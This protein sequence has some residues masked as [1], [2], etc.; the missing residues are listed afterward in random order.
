[1]RPFQKARPSW[2]AS[3]ATV[4]SVPPPDE[5]LG[6]RARLSQLEVLRDLSAISS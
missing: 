1:M 3:W 2:Q 5:W 4:L 6:L